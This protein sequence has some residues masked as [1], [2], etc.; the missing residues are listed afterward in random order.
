MKKNDITTSARKQQTEEEL[1]PELLEPAFY[2]SECRSL[3]IDTRKLGDNKA[4]G[5]LTRSVARRP[6]NLL[7]Q[8]QRVNIH[9]TQ[10]DTEGVYGSL[11]DLFITLNSKGR[12]IR[13]RMLLRA[14]PLLTEEQ[15]Q[16]L[17]ERLDTGISATDPMPLSTQSVLS[18][19]LTG[20][21]QLIERINDNGSETTN[22]DPLEEAIEYL[23]YSQIEKA[24]EIL[25]NAVLDNPS[26]MEL[27][28]NL[29]T[30]YRVSDDQGSFAV[31][32]DR[33]NALKIPVPD[34][35]KRLAEHF[36]T[37]SE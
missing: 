21:R 19:G 26:R 28:N 15:F 11:L 23:E 4:V 22:R 37:R 32:L 16:A 1:S 14:K 35:W 34:D 5:Y 6:E 36:A 13:R 10:R 8:I 31:M 29:L 25:E 2:L 33:L 9:L 24:R 18:K 12:S 30:I 7:A 3:Q 20:T 27:H 17:A